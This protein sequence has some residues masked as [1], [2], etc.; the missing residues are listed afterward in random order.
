MAG[1]AGMTA[2][3]GTAPAKVTAEQVD[4]GVVVAAVAPVMVLSDPVPAKAMAAQAAA[5]DLAT[6]AAATAPVMGLRVLAPIAAT[7]A[8]LAAEPALV[9]ATA[10]RVQE[11][12]PAAVETA[13]ALVAK[14]QAPEAVPDAVATVSRQAQEKDRDKADMAAAPNMTE[15][16]HRERS[17]EILQ[18]TATP[19]RVPMVFACQDL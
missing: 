15:A 9:L 13:A 11:K 10:A 18:V 8:D 3:T 1:S 5:L 19:T 2:G 14:V 12:V 4:T 17:E 6:E 7:A 16:T